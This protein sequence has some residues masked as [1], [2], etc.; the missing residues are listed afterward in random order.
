MGTVFS[1]S[2]SNLN[3]VATLEVDSVLLFRKGDLIGLGDGDDPVP[4][5]NSEYDIASGIYYVDLHIDDSRAECCVKHID[6]YEGYGWKFVADI[7]E[8]IRNGKR[9]T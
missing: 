1:I 5:H 7:V 8:W 9:D 4:V 6:E 2:E 3:L